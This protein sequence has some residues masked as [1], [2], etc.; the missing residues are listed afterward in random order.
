M[1]AGFLL[2][3]FTQISHLS[4]PWNERWQRLLSLPVSGLPFMWSALHPTSYLTYREPLLTSVKLVW[5]AF[6]LLR[7]ARGIQRVLDQD[8]TP[9]FFGFGLDVLKIMWGTR[10]FAHIWM[11]FTMIQSLPLYA[12]GQVYGA[13]MLRMNDSLC[14][15]RVLQDPLTRRRLSVFNMLS[16]DVLLPHSSAALMSGWVGKDG[17]CA[18]FL[19]VLVATLGVS[20]PIAVLAL[21]KMRLGMKEIMV[22]FLMCLQVTW[23]VAVVGTS[24]S[25]GPS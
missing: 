17:D 13:V 22:A 15:T 1:L 6:P 16:T 4:C 14:H 8:A 5:F 21:S 11:S 10:L 25:M 18:F 23:V 7:K 20:L 2:H 24:Y 3:L 12:L 9:G 19:T